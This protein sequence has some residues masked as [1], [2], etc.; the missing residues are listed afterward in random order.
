[1]GAFISKQ[2]NGLYC[3]FSTVVDCPT[4]WNMTREEYLSNVTGTV[5]DK[6]EGELILQDYLRPF[7]EVI[8]RFVP[9]N[10]REEKFDN[11]LQMMGN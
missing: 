3:R 5:R 9:N 6:E 7:S 1:M 10:M 8:E 4:H 2:P 11:L